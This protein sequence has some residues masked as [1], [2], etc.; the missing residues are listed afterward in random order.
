MEWEPQT[1]QAMTVTPTGPTPV[2]CVVS[3]TMMTSSRQHIAVHA[4]VELIAI[5]MTM[6]KQTRTAII[7]KPIT[8][9]QP[10]VIP[11]L[12]MMTSLQHR[13]AVHA[14]VAQPYRAVLQ[15]AKD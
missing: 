6:E 14:A 5:A 10:C 4:T 12:T 13:F 7:A 11:T 9:I 8:T 3:L 1:A 2:T 15:A